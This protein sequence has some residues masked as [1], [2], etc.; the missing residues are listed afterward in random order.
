MRGVLKPLAYPAFASS[1]LASAKFWAR[2]A[3]GTVDGNT[4]AKGLSLPRS[5]YPLKSAFTSPGRSRQRAIAWRT[6]LDLKGPTSQRIE[7]SRWAEPLSLTMLYEP[8][9]S[10]GLEETK[11]WSRQSS[12]LAWRAEGIG[13]SAAKQKPW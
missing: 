10:C 12:W 3:T 7:S 5:A 9:S 4:G 13:P 2:W 1:F 8:F 6:S 11:N